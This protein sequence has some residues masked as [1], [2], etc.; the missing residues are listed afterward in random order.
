[1]SIPQPV[2]EPIEGGNYRL[3]RNYRIQHAGYHFTILKGFVYDGASIPRLVWPIIG[4]T[5]DG[6]LR[7]GALVHDALYRNGGVMP[8]IDHVFTRKEADG[9]FHSLMA[10]AGV[11]PRRA[12]L[13]YV[14]VRLFGRWSFKE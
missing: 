11:K 6:L 14:G 13:A 5:P 7:G 9:I 4:M 3:V 1:M 8:G 2:N 12:Y 10:E